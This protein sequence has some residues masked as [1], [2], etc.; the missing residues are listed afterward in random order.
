MLLCMQKLSSRTDKKKD[1]GMFGHGLTP[2]WLIYV[3]TLGWSP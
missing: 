3:A 1:G 2:F